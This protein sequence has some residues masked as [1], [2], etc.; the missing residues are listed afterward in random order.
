MAVRLS[1]LLD[2]NQHSILLNRLSEFQ[3]SGMTETDRQIFIRDVCQL[4]GRS[5]YLVQPSLEQYVE[6][7]DEIDL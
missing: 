7:H 3:N 4:C 6:V 1:T 2:D 5:A